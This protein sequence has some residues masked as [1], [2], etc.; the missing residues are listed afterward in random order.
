MKRGLDKY[1]LV[2]AT[3]PATLTCYWC[4]FP[5]ANIRG[6]RR[7]TGAQHPQ[8]QVKVRSNSHADESEESTEESDIDDI[9]DTED[10]VQQPIPAVTSKKFLEIL[11]LSQVN[12]EED[13]DSA[14]NS[15]HRALKPSWRLEWSTP[16]RE[17]KI[18]G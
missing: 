9:S 10:R 8:Q 16:H 11:C 5:A 7:H 13:R 15:Q 1:G 2:A 4:G 12:P 6:L 18:P 17:I 14:D 3:V